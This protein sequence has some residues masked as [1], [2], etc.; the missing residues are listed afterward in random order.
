[1]VCR[2]TSSPTEGRSLP[3]RSGR[4]SARPWGRPP[5]CLRDITPNPTVRP[6]VPIRRWRQH[7]AASPLLSHHPGLPGVEYAH[8]TLPNASS[9]MSPF[10]C[11]QIRR[12]RSLS[13]RSRPICAAVMALGGVLVLPCSMLPP[14]LRPRPTVAVPRRPLM[15]RGTGY[16]SSPGIFLSR[17]TLG[18]LP[19]GML[20]PVQSSPLSPPDAAPPLPPGWR[21]WSCLHGAVHPGHAVPGAWLPLPGG[22]GGLW[23]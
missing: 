6:S 4:P 11:S 12:P 7:S 9:G 21:T 16:G 8:N 18:N 17:W 1:M 10:L 22:L 5:A 14:G 3:P 2:Q 19:P 13:L 15:L 20:E 23:S